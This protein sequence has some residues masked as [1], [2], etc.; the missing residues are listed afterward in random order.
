MEPLKPNTYDVPPSLKD[1]EAV[2]SSLRKTFGALLATLVSI[3]ALVLAVMHNGWFVG[4]WIMLATAVGFLGVTGWAFWVYIRDYHVQYE[5][6]GVT[7]IFMNED[8]FVPRAVMKSFIRK[9]VLEPFEPHWDG[10]IENMLDGVSIHLTPDKPTFHSIVA[11]GMTWPLSSYS[12]VW[13]PQVLNP[14]ALGYELKLHACHRIHGHQPEKK[15][16]AWMQENG[17]V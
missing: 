1:D 9:Q 2:K 11:I 6:H 5:V 7:L 10:N 15:D 4:T 12:R 3:T 16:L 8:Y 13:A 14:G 17:I